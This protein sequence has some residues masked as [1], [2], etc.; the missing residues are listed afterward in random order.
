[1]SVGSS[2]AASVR[3]EGLGKCAGE[4]EYKTMGNW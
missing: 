4:M 2:S 3:L 1:M